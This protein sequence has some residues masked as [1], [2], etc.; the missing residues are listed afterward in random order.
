VGALAGAA[1]LIR[2]DLLFASVVVSGALMWRFAREGGL[3][4]NAIGR[5][6]IP[7]L[8]VVVAVF[9]YALWNRAHFGRL[10][11]VPVAGALGTSL[12]LATWQEKVPLSDLLPLYEGRATERAIRSGLIQEVIELNRRVGAPPLTSPFDPQ[13]Y[14]TQRMQIEITKVSRD[15]AIERIKE[16]PADYAKHVMWNTV[17]LW[18]TGEYP[19]S[20]PTVARAAL[21][22]IAVFTMFAGSIGALL[23]IFGRERFRKWRP[24]ALVMFYPLA[25]HI[26]IHTEARYTAAAR[27]LLLLFAALAIAQF[28]Q[29]AWQFR[30]ASHRGLTRPNGGSGRRDARPPHLRCGVSAGIL[31]KASG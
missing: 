10:T 17:R 22:F 18:I 12:Y 21:T 31:V 20:V 13:R 14:P 11:P 15:K 30:Q 8:C 27:P 4:L 26:W 9:P 16:H 2:S 5:A 3:S 6:L 1:A 28:A 19:K 24:A 29:M 23:A 7:P 25:I